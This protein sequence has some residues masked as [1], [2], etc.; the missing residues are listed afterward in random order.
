MADRQE[1]PVRNAG[2]RVAV[3]QTLGT[4]DLIVFTARLWEPVWFWELP[5]I[6]THFTA[7]RG[8]GHGQACE[9]PG[10]GAMQ[11]LMRMICI[12]YAIFLTMLL[13]ANHPEWLIGIKGEWPWLLQMLHPAAHIISFCVLAVLALTTRWPMPRWSIV[14]ILAIYGGLT[15]I[16][17]HF[18]VT[19][20][21]RWTD[22]LRDLIGIALGTACCWGVAMLA[23][24]LAGARRNPQPPPS[25]SSLE[26]TVTRRLLQRSAA[27]ERSWWN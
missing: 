1:F 23:G 27:S 11:W 18:T 19:R 8:A 22:W 9:E 6:E 7:A 12:A 26:W 15:E 5:S 21:P 10:R 14:L 25:E 2:G 17:Q 3:L 24:M 4:S 13:L 20:T 16:G